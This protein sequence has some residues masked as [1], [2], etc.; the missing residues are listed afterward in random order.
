MFCPECGVEFREGFDTCSDC[1]VALVAECP[2]EPETPFAKMVAVFVGTELAT[3][4][5]AKSLLDDA[6]IHYVEKGEQVQDLFG[7]LRVGTGGPVRIEVD[8]EHAAK[9]REVLAGL[10]ME[11]RAADA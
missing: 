6:G 10:V 1:G 7:F 8:E 11:D 4:M 9:A 2:Q 5:R 3:V